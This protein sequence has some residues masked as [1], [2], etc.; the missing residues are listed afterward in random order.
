MNNF[1]FKSIYIII[2]ELLYNIYNIKYIYIYIYIHPCKNQK[3]NINK[4]RKKQI[5]TSSHKKVFGQLYIYIY[6]YIIYTIIIS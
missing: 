6:I 3:K 1:Y 2:I 5:K 4:P